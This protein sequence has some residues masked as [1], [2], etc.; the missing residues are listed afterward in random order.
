MTVEIPSAAP[1]ARH[2]SA[3][4]EHFTPK[5]IVELAREVLGEIDLDPASCA[6]ANETVR[7]KRIYTK[8]LN[9]FLLPLYGKVFLNPPGGSCDASGQRIGKDCETTG[10]CGLPPG[11]AH[12]GRQSSAKA[13]WRKAVEAVVS[14]RAEA[15][16]F[17]GFT[18]EILQT[19]QTEP[20]F[21]AF[22]DPMPVP[23]DFPCCIPTKRVS[24]FVEDEHGAIRPGTQPTHASFLTIATE[25]APMKAKFAE[26]FRGMGRIV[27][28]W[29][30]A[31]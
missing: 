14:R 12:K 10:A 13:W 5:E 9:G 7:A 3:S 27:G 11:H 21:D 19:T 25:D 31:P 30:G 8:E 16:F 23:L 26:R 1:N 22:G 15:V 18:L 17:V 24:Y 2:S 20:H 28:P 29:G 6:L 4:A